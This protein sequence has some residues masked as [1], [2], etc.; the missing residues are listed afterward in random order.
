MPRRHSWTVWVA[1]G[2]LFALRPG[3]DAWPQRPHRAPQVSISRETRALVVAPHP[4][5]E[6][7][8]AAGLMQRVHAAGGAVRV[9]YLTGADRG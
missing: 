7:L 5:D 3:I 1:S 8:A 9:V 2:A 4:D 6:M